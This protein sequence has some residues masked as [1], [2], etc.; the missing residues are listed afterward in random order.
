[1]TFNLSEF[2]TANLISCIQLIAVGIGFYFSYRAMK[3]TAE[4]LGLSAK[5]TQLAAKNAELAS[6]NAEL[7]TKSAQAT[8]FNNMVSQGRDLQHR[9]AELNF[10][11]DNPENKKRRLDQFIGTLISYYASC[12][13]LRNIINMPDSITRQY[14]NDLKT[15]L[16]IEMNKQKYESLKTNFSK[17]FN[18][19]VANLMNGV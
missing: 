9:F 8:L 1:M 10:G 13:E 6:K 4:G 2:N 14:D 15:S 11:G 5:N 17:E 3:A 16:S 18:N 12:F 19:Y 7:A